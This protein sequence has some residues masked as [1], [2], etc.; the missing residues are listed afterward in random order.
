MRPCPHW[1]PQRLCTVDSIRGIVRIQNLLR[2]ASRTATIA[3]N[4]RYQSVIFQRSNISPFDHVRGYA[5]VRDKAKPT[6]SDLEKRIEAIPIERYRNFCIVAHID[7][8][9]STL[10]DRLLEYTGTIKASDGNKQILV[11]YL[12]VPPL[13]PS[14]HYPLFTPNPAER[15]PT[16]PI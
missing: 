11:S 14:T 13:S 7:H 6:A 12:Y 4:P 5:T 15:G 1:Q 3:H 8:G 16:K 10:S 2:P 9:K